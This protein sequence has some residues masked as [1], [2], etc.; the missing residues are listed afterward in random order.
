MSQ[1]TY[2]SALELVETKN[3]ETALSE[4]LSMDDPLEH[5]LL[6]YHIGLCYTHL[7]RYD[8][9]LLYLEQVAGNQLDLVHLSRSA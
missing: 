4:L 2:E 6:S 5:P 1:E 3:F 8:E 9:A 7:G